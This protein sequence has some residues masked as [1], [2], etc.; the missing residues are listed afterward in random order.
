MK[1]RFVHS[2]HFVSGVRDQMCQWPMKDPT[3]VATI[4]KQK[5][6]IGVDREPQS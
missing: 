4:L 1:V 2:R 6:D 5:I 3:D